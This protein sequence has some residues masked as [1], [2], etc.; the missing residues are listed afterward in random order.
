MKL[1]RNNTPEQDTEDRRITLAAARETALVAAVQ[2]G[3]ASDGQLIRW[4]SRLELFLLIY[5][6]SGEQAL[7]LA[8]ETCKAR[9]PLDF[10]LV[11][12][13]AGNFAD[14]LEGKSGELPA[15]TNAA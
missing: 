14:F 1:A 3:S 7:T 9:A 11:C 5:P 8:I 10:N 6:A 4:A 2:I 13:T 15:T 12:D